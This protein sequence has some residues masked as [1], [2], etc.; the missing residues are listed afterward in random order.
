MIYGSNCYVMHKDKYTLN[1]YEI[2]INR[3]HKKFG[4]NQDSL[5]GEMI[6]IW[7]FIYI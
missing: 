7:Y 2:A 5:K 4:F 1:I 6:G 3:L